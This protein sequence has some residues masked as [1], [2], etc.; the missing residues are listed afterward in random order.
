MNRDDRVLAIVLAAQHLLGLAGVDLY[1]QLVK[2]ASEVVSDRFAGLGPFDQH[3]EVV[4]P[5]LQGIAQLH[6]LLEAAPALQQLLCVR[7]ILPEV[8]SG[9]AFFYF[10]K[11]DG[12]TGDVKD[13]SAGRRRVA[14]DP[15]TY[16]ADRRC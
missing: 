5:A 2:R 12:G 13:S 16:G 10:G 8:G 7:L 11:L 1:R 4:E 9:D 15:R 14:P 6:V 3:V